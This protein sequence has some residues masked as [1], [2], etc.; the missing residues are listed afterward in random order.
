MSNFHFGT[1]LLIW[2]GILALVIVIGVFIARGVEQKK[3]TKYFSEQY[4]KAQKK[5]ENARAKYA[6]N[7]AHLKSIGF[8]ADQTKMMA[9]RTFYFDYKKRLTAYESYCFDVGHIGSR[10]P[11][12]KLFENVIETAKVY[13]AMYGGA[14]FCSDIKV[15]PDDKIIE[16]ALLQAGAVVKKSDGSAALAGVSIPYFGSL[17]GTA[18]TGSSESQTG[19]LAVRLT[20]DD[21]TMPSVIFEI[22]SG[23]DKASKVYGMAFEQAQEL[24]GFFDGIARMNLKAMENSAAPQSA[25]AEQMQTA[26]PAQET[27]SDAKESTA[28]ENIFEMIRQLGKLKDDGLL[29]E[30]EFAAQKKSLMERL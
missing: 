1:F 11:K 16:C 17:Q 30:E 7:H 6:A 14:S 13:G 3:R 22:T 2:L 4:G 12:P 9:G 27:K 21:L 8:Q 24:F 5:L 19:I 29:S 23:A 10:P 25:S 28:K 18:S 26:K 15:F 20:L